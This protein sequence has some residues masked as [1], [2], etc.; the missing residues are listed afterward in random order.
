MSTKLAT[1]PGFEVSRGV[2][3]PGQNQSAQ[4]A[5]KEIVCHV[6]Q[7]E[8]YSEWDDLIDRS[9]HGTIFHYSWWLQTTAADFTIL[10]IRN[11]RGAIVAGMPI[12]RERR[13]GLRLLRSP[14]L[15]PYLGP[16][17]DL[18]SIDNNCDRLHFMRY[19]GEILARNLK[20]FDSVRYVAG[21]SAPDLQGFLWAGFRVHLAYTFRFP[22]THTLEQIAAGM[23]RTH[24]QKLTKALRLKLTVV[25]DDGVDDLVLLN[26]KT[27][28]KQGLKPVCSAEFLR[29]LWTVAR[30]QARAHLYVA[31]TSDDKPAAALLTVHDNRTTYQI[32]SGVNPEFRDVPGAYLVLWNALQDT[33]VAGRDYDFEGSS[34]RGVECFYRRWGA[35]AVPIW[36]LEKS[37]SWRGG[38]FQSLVDRRDLMALNK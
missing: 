20:S 17:F 25:R 11:E 12:P 9:P 3:R 35:T 5:P 24:L 27:F 8:D 4:K 23:T 38:L 22:A 30:S 32:V 1:Q 26:R 15:T 33:L 21:A 2:A 31:K 28:E 7:R 34:L 19:N 18:S 36:R 10:V 14:S 6:L 37:G 29:R 16:V 13:P